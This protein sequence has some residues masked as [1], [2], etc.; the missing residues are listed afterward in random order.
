MLKKTTK[1]IKTV[2]FFGDAEALEGQ[3]H[4]DLARKTAK[5][6]AENGYIVINGGGPGV[7]LASTLGAKEG[8]GRVELSIVNKDK[9]P[10]N[11][12][13]S[14]PLNLNLA[15]K[16]YEMGSYE[17]RLNKLVEIADAHVIFKG[18]TGTIAEVGLVW[19]KAKFDFGRHE[20]LIFV[21]KEW[22]K[23]VPVI[24]KDLNLETVEKEVYKLVETPEEV[25]KALT[26]VE[27]LT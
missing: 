26:T 7:M 11:F 14:S 10:N 9:L 13:G 8:N 17:N 24:V 23:I 15:D 4:F 20:P 21:G 1:D 5:L 19:S 18:G 22:E 6:L 16:I 12:E 2:A 3:R 25:L 27:S